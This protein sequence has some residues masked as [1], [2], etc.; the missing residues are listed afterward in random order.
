MKKQ[1]LKAFIGLTL[2]GTL[3]GCGDDFFNTKYYKGIDVETGLNS[4]ANIST[5]LNGTYDRL[6]NYRFAGNYAISI[7]D[8]PT[9]ISY[10]NTNTGHWDA[11]YKFTFTDTDIY[12]RQIWDY[13]YKVADNSARVIKASK[14]L[15][16]SSTTAEK[17]ELDLCMAE[18]YALRGY[19]HLMLVNIFSH[20]VKVNG[21]DHSSTPGIV[22]V[23]EPIQA[24]TEV[25]RSTVGDTY[26]A[27]LADLKNS[28]THFTAAGGDR[29][30]LVYF[31]EAS[32]YGLLARANLYLENWS[33]AAQNAQSALTAAGI[34]TL[35]YTNSTY[36]SLYNTGT[37]N[38]ESMFALAITDS[39]N[40]SANSCGTLWSTYNFSPSPKL[41]SLY[42]ANDCRTSIF[43]DG[44]GS[45]STVPVFNG[46]KFAHFSSGNSA[47]GTNYIVNAPEMF[48]II[49][50]ANVKNS[51]GT[52]SA[53]QTAL[54]TVAKRNADIT[55]VSD[56]PATK[57]ELMAFIKD[58]RARELF[59]EGFR[60][61]D[62]RRW[63]ES[64]SVYAYNYP[65]VDFTFK[66]YKISDLIFPIPS[67]EI[68]SGFGVEQN[69]NWSSTLPK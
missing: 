39:Q 66:N 4:V 18:A 26:T 56:L 43:E 7:G 20:Q 69:S 6:F 46:G 61:Y 54:L 62:L 67:N 63:D 40:W 59:Q 47:Y 10:W 29:E 5:A 37:S 48:L 16:E 33:D 50:E 64:A 34:T 38:N 42:G 65:N 17:A 1:I 27:I 32:V 52:V 30:S 58:E 60:L 9:D 3:S 22:I 19:A 8:V 15:Y 68:N 12:L 55:A 21:T 41:L 14:E 24:L 57:D 13:G 53:A 23:D 44:T 25:S 28:I 51:A 11:V 31:N 2:I 35:A 36:K 49:A 45:T